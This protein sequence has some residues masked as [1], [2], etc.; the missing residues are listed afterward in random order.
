MR[1]NI[2]VVED[3]MQNTYNVMEM[4]KGKCARCAVTIQPQYLWC[5]DCEDCVVRISSTIWKAKKRGS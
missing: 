5:D 3:A 1:Q 4:R 2:V